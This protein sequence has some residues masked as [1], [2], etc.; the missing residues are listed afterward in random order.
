MMYVSLTRSDVIAIRV[1]GV[2]DPKG[3]GLCVRV[4]QRHGGTCEETEVVGDEITPLNTVL[5]EEG[6]THLRMREE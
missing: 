5:E 1:V 4:E 3:G 6:M 2:G